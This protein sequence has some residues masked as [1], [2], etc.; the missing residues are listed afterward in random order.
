MPFVLSSEISIKVLEERRGRAV[1]ELYGDIKFCAIASRDNDAL[2]QSLYV[3]VNGTGA[4]TGSAGTS[5]ARA[6]I[7]RQ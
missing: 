3:A 7:P 2:C 4:I 1:R 5:V 6:R